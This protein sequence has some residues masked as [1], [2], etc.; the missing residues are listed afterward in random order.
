MT[1][2][3]GRVKARSGRPAFPRAHAA[4]LAQLTDSGLSPVTL[5]STGGVLSDIYKIPSAGM[6]FVRE[7]SGTLHM[8]LTD[9]L[10]RESNL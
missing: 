7:L 4:T 3:Q 6:T 1:L 5:N 9:G 2:N 8:I 10:K